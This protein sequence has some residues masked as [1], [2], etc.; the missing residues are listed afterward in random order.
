MN[1]KYGLQLPRTRKL[2]DAVVNKKAANY[3]PIVIMTTA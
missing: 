3:R 2:N 1:S